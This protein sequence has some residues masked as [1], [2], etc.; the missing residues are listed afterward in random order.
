MDI[1]K[2]ATT[3]IVTAAS[4]GSYLLL[5]NKG[6]VSSEDAI[7][8]VKNNVD[9]ISKVSQT[10]AG[11]T[12]DEADNLAKTIYRG[13]KAVIK[14]DK[15]TYV[16]SSASGKTKNIAEYTL[17]TA[18]EIV[19]TLFSNMTANSPRHFGQELNKLIKSKNNP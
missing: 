10:F 7:A 6:N 5:K 9:A 3:V 17:N 13:V 2:I 1:K 16:Y 15:V 8:T 14:E 11:V 12:Q 18:G 19:G 4:V